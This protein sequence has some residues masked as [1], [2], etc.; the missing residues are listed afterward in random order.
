MGFSLMF[1][2]FPADFKFSI[3][4]VQS[5]LFGQNLVGDIRGRDLDFDLDLVI[6]D[7][8]LFKIKARCFIDIF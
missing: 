3:F 1:F 7:S 5:V 4:T 8:R 6:I 2:F